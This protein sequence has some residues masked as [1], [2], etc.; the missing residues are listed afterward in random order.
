MIK[1]A[2][3]DNNNKVINIIVATDASISTL[4]GVFVKVDLVN[5]ASRRDAHIGG[6][7]N[8]LQDKFIA[9]KPYPSWSLNEDT[10]EWDAPVAKPDNGSIYMWDESTTSWIELEQVEI[11]LPGQNP[12]E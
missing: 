9:P 7:Y 2:E 8:S 12:V 6:E 4:P 1:F 11:N 3:L 10:L 5:N